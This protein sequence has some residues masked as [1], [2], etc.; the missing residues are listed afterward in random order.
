MN[1]QPMPTRDFVKSSILKHYYRTFWNI[2]VSRPVYKPR[3]VFRKLRYTKIT[4]STGRQE[5]F[6]TNIDQWY[7]RDMSARTL[8]STSTTQF[9]KTPASSSVTSGE[10]DPQ[11]P[12]QWVTCTHGPQP[13]PHNYP[14]LSPPMGPL[15]PW[16]STGC[17]LSQGTHT[18]DTP[19][20]TTQHY[21]LWQHYSFPPIHALQHI[22][23]HPK[24][25]YSPSSGSSSRLLKPHSRLG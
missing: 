24:V 21:P 23:L 2:H 9:P 8:G 5:D 11:E 19:E 18:N 1:T 16:H 15:Y 17:Y 14:H 3:A 12:V 6:I 7:P 25:R 22:K 20:C 4:P 10:Q 13:L